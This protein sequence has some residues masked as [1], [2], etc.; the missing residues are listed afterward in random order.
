MHGQEGSW[1]SVSAQYRKLIFSAGE[2]RE[3]KAGFDPS[4]VRKVLDEGGELPLRELVRCHVRYFNDGV[5]L[6]SRLFVEE[7][8][9]QNR[10]L[11]GER[12]ET[13]ARKMKGGDWNGLFCL[14]NLSRALAVPG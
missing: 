8:F 6:G 13:G 11:F 4:L 5:A 12:R 14:R 1:R 2:Q 3:N 7:V 10:A 9:E